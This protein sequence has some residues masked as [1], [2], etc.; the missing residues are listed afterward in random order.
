MTPE[1]W[2]FSQK[3]QQVSSL[4]KWITHHIKRRVNLF[5][6]RL[7]GVEIN[8]PRWVTW[9]SRCQKYRE[10]QSKYTDQWPKIA[11][12]T[13]PN[14]KLFQMSLK[15]A[16]H[17]WKLSFHFKSTKSDQRFRTTQQPMQSCGFIGFSSHSASFHT[18]RVTTQRWS[19]QRATPTLCPNT[20]HQLSP[21]LQ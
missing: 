15:E 7:V 18:R 16:S 17:F 5:S 12:T 4:K 3:M 20:P 13:N 6:C 14:C 21:N 19:S 9:D 10:Q 8:S 2:I 1:E 11:S